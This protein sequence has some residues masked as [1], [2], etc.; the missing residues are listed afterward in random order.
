MRNVVVTRLGVQ[1]NA[2]ESA[3]RARRAPL[4]SAVVLF[5][6]VFATRASPMTVSNLPQSGEIRLISDPPG[7]SVSI[8]DQLIDE[9]TPLRLDGLRPS[10][11]YSIRMFIPGFEPWQETITLVPGEART[12][13]VRLEA[14]ACALS[15]LTDPWTRVEVDGIDWGYTP[16]DARDL[17]S[18]KHLVVLRND[19]DLV[20]EELELDL[21][22]GSRT[23]LN[24]RFAGTIRFRVPGNVVVELDGR[25]LKS[26]ERKTTGIEVVS[27]FHEVRIVDAAFNRSQVIQAYVPV[28]GQTEVNFH[29]GEPRGP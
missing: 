2:T 22:P 7:A 6:F 13:G 17:P 23:N 4:T 24:V 21:E 3:K 29:F 27:G 8:N 12:L 26:F 16:I 5:L 25:E 18:G 15:V 1:R 14:P 11:P 20:H 28:R 10:V 19:T 9:L